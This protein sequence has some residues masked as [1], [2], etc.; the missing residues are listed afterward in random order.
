MAGLTGAPEAALAERELAPLLAL[1]PDPMLLLAGDGRVLR[2]N[3]AWARLAEAAGPPAGFA[4]AIAPADRPRAEA[5]LRRLAAGERVAGEALRLVP[6]EGQPRLL[7]WSGEG[8]GGQLYV[9]G[10][11]VT[12]QRRRDSL[13]A[14]E[15]RILRALADSLPLPQILDLVCHAAEAVLDGALCSVLLLSRDGARLLHGAAP[16]LPAAY[17]AAID[18]LAIG[19]ARGSCGTAAWHREPVIVEDIAD[20][21]L[22][23]EFSELGLAHDLRACWSTPLLSRGGEVLGT[24]AVY[25]HEPH[26]PQPWEIQVIERLTAST[27]I[28]VQRRR[29]DEALLAEKQ[30]A[31]LASRSKSEF[32]AN[33]SHELR[34]P[35]NAVLGFSELMRGE[36]LGPL[37]HPRYREFAADIHESGLHLLA[38][39]NDLLDLSR[40]EAGRLEL[41]EEPVEVAELLNAV[42]RLIQQRADQAQ[43]TLV[44]GSAEGLPRLRADR[45][46]LRQVLLNLLSNAIKFT[47]AA[48]QVALEAAREADGGISFLVRDTGIG[49]AVADIPKAL[50]PF[51]QVDS[52]LARKYQ[53]AGL[54]LP[55]SQ[56]LVEQHGGRLELESAPGIGTTVRVRLPPERTLPA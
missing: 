49:I 36:M 5:M 1:S 35:L 40:I 50:E 55:I 9:I 38:V 29:F 13:A 53:G 52:S 19:P 44:V 11:D 18:G 14:A 21:P 31:E 30:R 46:A 16:S 45:R 48:G 54:G 37:G 6:G 26:R 47:P 51:G 43:L 34:T 7:E 3:P 20:D 8:R 2:A 4:A 15:Q 39:I 27:A 10:R 24:F 22:W 12:E 23:A 41:Q 56:A 32:L 42:R 25:R 17:C 28:A 33:T